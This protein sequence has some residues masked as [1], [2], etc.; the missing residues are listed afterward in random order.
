MS[1]SRSE[2]CYN[3]TDTNILVS[4]ETVLF[5][6]EQCTYWGRKRER[7]NGGSLVCVWSIRTHVH[8]RCMTS[9]NRSICRVSNIRDMLW[10]VLKYL[11]S[12]LF[13]PSF[14][15]NNKWSTWM[16]LLSH[17]IFAYICLYLT[18]PFNDLQV[19][20]FCRNFLPFNTHHWFISHHWIKTNSTMLTP[21]IKTLRW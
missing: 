3:S 21:T 12:L 19:A 11:P 13:N 14:S 2:I 10:F 20:S 4:L 6:W 9:C 8:N 7:E 5:T 18:S 16:I 15:F 1:S 17:D